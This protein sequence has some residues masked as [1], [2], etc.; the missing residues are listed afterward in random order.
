MNYNEPNSRI[1]YWK[2][3][4]DDERRNK[5]PHYLPEPLIRKSK[6]IEQREMH[7]LKEEAETYRQLYFNEQQKQEVLIGELIERE[8]KKSAITIKITR[9]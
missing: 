4:Y 7:A 2:R 3:Y 8:R 6:T 9:Y 1:G 5:V